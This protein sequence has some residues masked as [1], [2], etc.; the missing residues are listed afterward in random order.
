MIL[1][2][3]ST[4]HPYAHFY[5]YYFVGFSSLSS[6]FLAPLE[7]MRH[8]DWNNAVE[9]TCPWVKTVV[10]VCFAVSFIV[11]RILGWTVVS[12]AYWHDNW[13]LWN[14]LH[15]VP[16]AL[17]YLFVGNVVTT[18]LQFIWAEKIIRMAN[19]RLTTDAQKHKASKA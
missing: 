13:T 6:C 18:M 12:L 10:T 3:I 19:R 11:F 7:V 16:Q 15:S 4:A 1:G 9:A 5:V 14:E 2:M 17:F 8:C